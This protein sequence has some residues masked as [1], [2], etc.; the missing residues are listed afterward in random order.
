MNIDFS[1]IL[2]ALPPLERSLEKTENT[3]RHVEWDDDVHKS[4]ASYIH[5]CNAAREVLRNTLNR[6]QEI[7]RAAQDIKQ[8]DEVASEIEKFAQQCNEIEV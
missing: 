4:Y 2:N 8:A 6:L 3:Y 7:Q 5:E 1:T